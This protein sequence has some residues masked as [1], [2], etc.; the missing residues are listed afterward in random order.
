MFPSTFFFLT[1]G[2]GAEKLITCVLRGLKDHILKRF[3]PGAS[4]AGLFRDLDRFAGL[5][6]GLTY[7]FTGESTSKADKFDNFRSMKILN[8]PRTQ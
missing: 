3:S 6:D 8:T 2:Q 4:F 1:T 5:F 7:T